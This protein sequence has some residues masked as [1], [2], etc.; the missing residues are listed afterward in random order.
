M[1]P[2]F[3]FLSGSQE[4]AG[5]RLELDKGAGVTRSR[6]VSADALPSG[7][8]G[9]NR[10]LCLEYKAVIIGAAL[11]YTSAFALNILSSC[12][13]VPTPAFKKLE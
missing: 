13:L 4:A 2:R 7:P 5:L 9:L 1:C 12:F 3:F 6:D 11:F 10:P 8:A